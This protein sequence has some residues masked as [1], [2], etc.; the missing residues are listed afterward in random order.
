MIDKMTQTFVALRSG[1]TDLFL[2]FEKCNAPAIGVQVSAAATLREPGEAEGHIGW[3]VAIHSKQLAHMAV[4]GISCAV[5]TTDVRPST[6]SR[7]GCR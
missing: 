3:G 1:L 5:L 2:T 6:S 7:A 4:N